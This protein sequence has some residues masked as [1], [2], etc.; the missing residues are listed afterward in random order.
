MLLNKKLE[1]FA[2][3]EQGGLPGF[4]SAIGSAFEKGDQF[5]I[6]VRGANFVKTGFV[7]EMKLF[8]FDGEDIA[9]ACGAGEGD[10]DIEGDREDAVGITGEGKG[11][12]CSGE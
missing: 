7:T 4:G 11:G 2:A 1:P 9:G 12:V 3:L 8:G 6:R 5:S 10:G